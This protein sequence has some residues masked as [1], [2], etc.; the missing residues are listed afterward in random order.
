[1]PILL[2]QDAATEPTW[3]RPGRSLATSERTRRRA[4]PAK[5]GLK[6]GIFVADW[7]QFATVL[8]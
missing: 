1:M 5:L 6:R 2:R 4:A 8:A 7:H 3:H